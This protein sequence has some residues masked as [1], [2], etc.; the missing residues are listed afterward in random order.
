MHVGA[1]Q[2][3]EHLGVVRPPVSGASLRQT[4]TTGIMATGGSPDGS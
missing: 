3:L 2:Q 1:P 4:C